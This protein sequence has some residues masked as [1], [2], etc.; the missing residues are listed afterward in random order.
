MIKELSTFEGIYTINAKKS[1]T[2]PSLLSLQIVK[3]S[4]Q[5]VDNFL[6]YGESHLDINTCTAIW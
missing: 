3:C 6:E 2:E 4:K 5:K 1:M